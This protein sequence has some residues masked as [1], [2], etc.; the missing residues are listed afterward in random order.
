MSLRAWPLLFAL[1]ALAPGDAR[2]GQ[3]APST[4][5]LCDDIVQPDSLDPYKVFS[6]KVHTIL[7][8]VLEGLVRFGPEGEVVPALAERWER[9][10][11]LTLRFHLERG[12]RFHDGTPLDAESVKASLERYAD[13]AT[14]FPGRSFIDTLER[15]DI[16]DAH[17][18][19]VRT[20]TRDGL[21]LNR[22][23]A[24]VHIVPK[25][26]SA[27]MAEHPVGTGPFRF[28]SWQ[29]GRSITLLR[30]E[31]YRLPG[32]P[33]VDRLV[34]RFIPAERQLEEFLAGKVDIWME[35]PGTATQLAARA[36]HGRVIKKRSFYTLASNFRIDEG[37]LKD[38]RVRRAL[39][40]AIDRR[41]LIRYDLMGNGVPL[42]TFSMPGEEGHHP[43]LEPFPY[44]P[45]LAKRLLEEA[46]HGEGL[47]L[48]AFV[49]S[50]GARAARIIQAQWRKVGVDLEYEVK[51]EGDFLRDLRSSGVHLAFGGCPDPMA[52]AYFIQSICL[53]SVS[54]FSIVKDPE[55]DRLLTTMVSTLDGAERAERARRLDEYV[56]ENAL[57]LFTYQ[58][59]KTY[60]VRRNLNFEPSVTG[61]P[62]LSSLERLPVTRKEDR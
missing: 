52:H 15:V 7:Q 43:G 49:K 48:R 35:L 37:P 2:P 36:P 19:D 53:F 30:N 32:E 27:S 50:T 1:T 29:K 57:G 56:H 24:W 34:F 44:D 62:Y 17:T 5:V 23:A 45:A 25:G 40:Y 22:L 59:I 20:R 28:G 16:V 11:D 13:P 26:Y 42:A 3:A 54:P 55:Y 61:M 31:D 41:E 8:Q 6:E 9:V 33:K 21:L 38:L 14:R 39:N 12:V 60:G 51:T 58:K 10:D 18:V 4:V 47:R 46:G